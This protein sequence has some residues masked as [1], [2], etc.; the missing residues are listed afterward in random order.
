MAYHLYRTVGFVFGSSAFGEADKTYTIFSKDLGFI[1][2]SAKSVRL[3]ASKLRA[4]LDDFSLTE[5]SLIRG[6]D[7]WKITGA[8]SLS[9]LFRDLEKEQEKRALCA[10]VFALLKKVL[11][12]EEKNEEL[13]SILS[14]GFSDLRKGELLKE[15]LL[16]FECVLLQRI[17]DNLGY[18]KFNPK[19]EDVLKGEIDSDMIRRAA[20]KKTILLK[21]I[22]EALRASE[23]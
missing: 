11:G 8:N 14:E 6:K 23:G 15:E 20:K 5:L 18:L 9:N 1:T 7:R 13:F 19:T 21:D 10:R 2:A 3:L 22:N 16:I 17:L 12:G 4:H